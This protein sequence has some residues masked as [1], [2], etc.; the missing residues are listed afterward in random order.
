[1]GATPLF[2]AI[3]QNNIE[4]VDALCQKGAKINKTISFE[5]EVSTCI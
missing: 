1:M 2:Y 4:I 5:D 3:M